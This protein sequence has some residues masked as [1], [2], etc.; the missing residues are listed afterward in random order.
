MFTIIHNPEDETS[1][2][3]IEA[4]PGYTVINWQDDLQRN[5]WTS[6]TN[7][8]T[9]SAFPSVVWK[10][11]EAY[12]INIKDDSYTVPPRYEVIRLPESMNDAIRNKICIDAIIAVTL[13]EK[14]MTTEQE[15]QDAIDATKVYY[16]DVSD[17]QTRLDAKKESN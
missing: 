15:A 5:E 17:L 8:N 12:K 9:I 16:S 2:N 14:N 3:F 13:Y 10:R 7:C 11:N 6:S 1:R 4:N